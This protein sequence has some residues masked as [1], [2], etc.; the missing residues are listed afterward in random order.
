MNAAERAMF[1]A[2]QRAYAGDAI[3]RPSN[4][5][6][7]MT[8]IGSTQL[9][10]RLPRV[11]QR[12]SQAARQG[13]GAHKLGETVLTDP[14]GPTPDDFV[15]R[16]IA[17]HDDNPSDT[18]FVD[19][20]MGEKI[21]EY[22]AIVDGLR[23]Q[24]GTEVFVEQKL[25]L[26]VLDPTNPLLNE[27]RG[28]GD[29]VAVN[30]TQLWITLLDLKYGVGVPVNGDARQ[31][32]V[33]LLMALLKFAAP[34]RGWEW[35]S[36]I[37]FQPR[38]PVPPYSE[39]DHYK[40]FVFKPA[41]ILGDFLGEV[42]EAMYGA[43]QPN[44]KLVPS[45]KA[46]RWC[47]ARRGCPAVREAGLS[48]AFGGGHAAPPMSYD[49]SALLQPFPTVSLAVQGE[50]RAVAMPP[51]MGYGQPKQVVLPPAPDLTPQEIAR[52][53]DGAEMFAIWLSS[54][55]HHAAALIQAGA[56]VPGYH[57]KQRTT[58]RRWKVPR[59]VLEEF[60]LKLKMKPME[61]YTAPKLRSP[62]QIEDALPKL[63]KGAIAEMYERPPGELT[64][65]S[66]NEPEQQPSTILSSLTAPMP[67][68]S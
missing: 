51:G 57:L 20:E 62:K 1:T 49:S 32:R 29:L 42:I 43:L 18:V 68:A 48:F 26:G 10:G 38:L 39:D 40:A 22:V 16:H 33:Y 67:K 8:C 56:R 13:S 58:Q 36:T 7:W 2:L 61:I 4:A 54:V 60:L 66:G 19:E 3:F 24:P 9:I 41:E 52:I 50:P 6:R 23:A 55:K 53:L 14:Q 63:L 21:T 27:C 44:P 15:G 12:T 64:L 31:L 25:S 65:V 34:G 45:E 46:C 17:I 28:T 35:G 59:E 5:D 11:P 47:E 37:V 30:L